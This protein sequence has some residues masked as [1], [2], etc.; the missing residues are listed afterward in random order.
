MQRWRAGAPPTSEQYNAGRPL[1]ESDVA[2]SPWRQVEASKWPH[3]VAVM[4]LGAN[5]RVV[6]HV[7]PGHLHG[8]THWR[9]VAGALA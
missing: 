2:R 7:G 6:V 3:A 4:T 5:G 1:R 8:V 9:V